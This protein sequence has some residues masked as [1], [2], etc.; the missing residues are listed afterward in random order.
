MRPRSKLLVDQRQLRLRLAD[1]RHAGRCAGAIGLGHRRG[2]GVL[3]LGELAAPALALQAQVAVEQVDQRIAG[4]DA[5][6]R[7]HMRGLDEAIGRRRPARVAPRLRYGPARRPGVRAAPRP[8]TAA[9]RRRRPAA[10]ASRVAAGWRNA[11]T[12]CRNSR[13]ARRCQGCVPCCIQ[14]SAGTASAISCSRRSSSAASKAGPWLRSTHSAPNTSPPTPSGSVATAP[15]TWRCSAACSIRMRVPSSP[16]ASVAGQARPTPW[17]MASS[18]APTRCCGSSA[19]AFDNSRFELANSR[20]R[21]CSCRPMDARSTPRRVVSAATRPCAAAG[22]VVA[23]STFAYNANAAVAGSA[24]SCGSP[25]GIGSGTVPAC[26][27]HRV[28]GHGAEGGQ[29]SS[30]DEG[31]AR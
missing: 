24:P 10:G 9:L 2:I 6:A 5:V 25:T 3:V 19:C 13:Q 7:S 22:S 28:F 18:I 31:R 11:A 14:R 1:A 27:M 29:R 15:P 20:V 4:L 12:A 8:R 30:P 23:A 16:A 17:S 26:R 21:P